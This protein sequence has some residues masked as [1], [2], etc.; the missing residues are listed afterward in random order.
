MPCQAHL[1]EVVK[2]VGEFEKLGVGVA[3][4]SMSRPEALTAYLQSNPLPFPV[5]ADPERKGYAAFGLGRTSWGKMLRPRVVWRYL[6]QIARGG[7]IRRIPEGED[8]LQMGGDF[9]I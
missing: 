1:V 7:K 4:V 5:V 2:R 8:P 3:A 9:I 6:K